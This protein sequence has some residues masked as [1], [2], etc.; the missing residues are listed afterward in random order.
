MMVL[1]NY[2]ELNAWQVAVELTEET[3]RVT[4]TFPA[5]E[6]YGLTS[7]MN[8]SAVSIPSNITEGYGRNS[9]GEY[10]QRLGIARGSLCELETQ[11][12]ICMRLKYIS[13][14]DAISLL[15]KCTTISKLIVGL[16]KSLKNRN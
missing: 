8:R 16:I 2:R 10:I 5:D 4:R 15:D 12:E 1:S 9:T 13:E 11:I 6:R 14:P 7:Q 3:Y